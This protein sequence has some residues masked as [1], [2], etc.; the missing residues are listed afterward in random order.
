[1]IAVDEL[2]SPGASSRFRSINTKGNPADVRCSGLHDAARAPSRS[3][4][5]NQEPPPSLT[6]P[7]GGATEVGAEPRHRAQRRTAL[8]YPADASAG[9]KAGRRC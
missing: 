8:A 9:R 1:M 2:P 7:Q 3:S 6:R 4:T 5:A